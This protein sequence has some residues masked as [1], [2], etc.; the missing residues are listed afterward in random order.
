MGDVNHSKRFPHDFLKSVSKVVKAK[1]KLYLKSDMVQ[2][3]F[4]PPVKIVTDKDSYKHR[5]RQIIALIT[6]FPQ[7]ED[8][9]QHVYVA[10]P[11]V[12]R[13]SGKEVAENI[14]ESVKK[15]TLPEQYQGGSYDGAYIHDNPKG[16]HFDTHN[17]FRSNGLTVQDILSKKSRLPFFDK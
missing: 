7:A 8:F 4:K 2:T 3:G 5:T 13:H 16:I 12:K 1:L 6:V 17:I 14:H 15:F 9:I 11:V 10:H